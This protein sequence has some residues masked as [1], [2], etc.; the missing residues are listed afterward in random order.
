MYVQGLCC[1]TGG[2][3][4]DG[5]LSQSLVVG[6]I[7]GGEV[8]RDSRVIYKALAYPHLSYCSHTWKYSSQYLK[9]I[10]KV[11]QSCPKTRTQFGFRF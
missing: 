7:S 11:N 6:G 4:L 5:K 9:W 2:W 1:A 3:L 8:M 10:E